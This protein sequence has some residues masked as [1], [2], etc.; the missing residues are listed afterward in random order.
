MGRLILAV[1]R[2][3][4]ADVKVEANVH[5]GVSVDPLASLFSVAVSVILLAPEPKTVVLPA[6]EASVTVTA[7]IVNVTV[8]FLVLSSLETAVITAEQFEVIV[9]AGGV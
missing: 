5:C 2:T 1:L 4:A 7:L 3:P 6:D 8:L 9:S